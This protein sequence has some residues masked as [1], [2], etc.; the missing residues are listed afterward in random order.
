MY[1]K[2]FIK[3]YGSS[4][5]SPKHLDV[6]TNKINNGFA[7]GSAAI[8]ELTF[9]VYCEDSTASFPVHAVIPKS[10]GAH[11]AFV[12]ISGLPDIPNR[13]LPA[14]E[15]ADNGCAVFI[16][17]KEDIAP[18]RIRNGI[19][20]SLLK[21]KR[22]VGALPL[23]AFTAERVAE[24]IQT[25]PYIDRERVC[26]SAHGELA[27]AA[28][29]AASEC[30]KFQYA[31]LNCPEIAYSGSVYSKSCETLSEKQYFSVITELIN[32]CKS[33][34]LI[35]LP[36]HEM[37]PSIFANARINRRDGLSYFSRGDWG[38][39]LSII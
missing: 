32:T 1:S 35:S 8:H 7:A 28:L 29:L 31:A 5:A 22:S 21:G 26:V 27:E 38:F 20:G 12:Y 11:P 17:Y 6:V 25:L 30:K 4:P 37:L 36:D 2:E 34:I 16:I 24:Y 13:Y 39:Y 33:K 23:L 18:S 10:R 19:A 3:R 15:I 14:E 9:I